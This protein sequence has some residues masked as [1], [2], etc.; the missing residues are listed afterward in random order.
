[1]NV[2][3]CVPYQAILL[4]IELKELAPVIHTAIQE[5]CAF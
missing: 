2:R 3:P 1:M 4:H 5:R